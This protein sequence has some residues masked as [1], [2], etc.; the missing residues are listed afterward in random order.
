MKSGLRVWSLDDGYGDGKLFNG[1]GDVIV[2]PNYIML[3]TTKIDHNNVDSMEEIDPLS[4]IKFNDGTMNYLVG[5]I[6]QKRGATWDG[7]P[8]AKHTHPFF[9]KFLQANLGL[10]AKDE[11][12]DEVEVDLLVMALPY[13]AYN[14]EKR[15]KHLQKIA[16][17]K[18]KVYV[19][20]ADGTIIDKTIIIKEVLIHNQPFGSY[21]YHVLDKDGEVKDAKYVRQNT[22]VWDLGARTLNVLAVGPKFETLTTYSY[23]EQVGMYKAWKDIGE[24]LKAI[25]ENITLPL[26]QVPLACEKGSVP[27]GGGDF[28]ITG[29][30]DTF[31]LQH[32]NNLVGQFAGKLGEFSKL[33]H[34]IIATGGGV[35]VLGKYVKVAMKNSFPNVPVVMA[36]RKTTVLGL[37]AYGMRRAKRAI[38]AHSEAAANKEE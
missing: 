8:E 36:G 26:A 35:D 3:G 29:I 24:Y 5:E 19:E 34:S 30:R 23:T 31:Y 17:N 33:T 9:I 11:I 32:A 15:V 27:Y 2:V 25:P 16:K 38:K 37:H 6:A 20:L 22:L 18:H 14:D 7:S 28:E 4:V 21:I 10:L 12:E 13:D 1:S